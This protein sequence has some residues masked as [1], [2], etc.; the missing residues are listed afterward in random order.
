[1]F[2]FEGVSSV[3]SRA[4]FTLFLSRARGIII[5]RLR[6]KGKEKKE[7]KERK[8]KKEKSLYRR[9]MNLDR[10][11]NFRDLPLELHERAFSAMEN[12]AILAGC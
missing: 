10:G 2:R 3:R 1:V 5:R 4:G 9:S 8:K 11:I 12:G 6:K 7:K